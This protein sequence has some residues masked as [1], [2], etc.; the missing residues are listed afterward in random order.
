MY[1]FPVKFELIY[2]EQSERQR[3]RTGNLCEYTNR[4][5][6]QQKVHKPNE[7]KK[8]HGGRTGH[9]AHFPT[10]RS[11]VSA[12]RRDSYSSPSVLLVSPLGRCANSLSMAN[13]GFIKS[14]V[15]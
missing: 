2:D 6:L 5:E 9:L 11:A 13:G 8:K 12:A 14:R 15:R 1:T 10:S 4:L 3:K 7:S